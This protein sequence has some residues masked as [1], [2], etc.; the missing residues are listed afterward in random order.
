MSWD[1]KEYAPDPDAFRPDRFLD[2][3][4]RDPARYVFG[5][6]RR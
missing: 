2:S 5:F 6:G 4:A 1:G 3:G